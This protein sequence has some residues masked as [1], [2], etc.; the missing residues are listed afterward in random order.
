MNPTIKSV[1]H[2]GTEGSF[3][4]LVASKHFGD[5]DFVACQ[6]VGEVFTFVTDSPEHCGIVPVENSTGG[7]IQETIR[8]IARE[9]PGTVQILEEI[10]L[11]VKLA[12]LGREGTEITRVYSYFAPLDHCRSWLGE[13]Y[14]EARLTSVGSTSQAAALAAEESGAAAIGTKKSA[15]LHGLKVLQYPIADEVPN[16][17]QFLVIGHPGQVLPGKAEAS[18][19]KTSLVVKLANEAGSLCRFL[20]VFDTRGVNLTRIESS[21]VVGEPN[22]YRFFIETD[23]AE[24]EETVVEALAAAQECSISLRSVGSYPADRR[25]QS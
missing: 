4:N 1:A 9:T 14:P 3:A 11:D 20:S 23:G 22:T 7:I 24:K 17:T 19:F 5:R 21:P 13:H 8:E 16:V 15:G 2:F 12:L 10:T 18:R 25:Y 6:T